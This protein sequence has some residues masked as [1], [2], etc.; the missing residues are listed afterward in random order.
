MITSVSTIKSQM[1]NHLSSSSNFLSIAD[2]HVF[3]HF[4]LDY[5]NTLYSF[6]FFHTLAMSLVFVWMFT[7]SLVSLS[8]P[9]MQRCGAT[10][11]GSVRSTCPTSCPSCRR[12]MRK[13]PPSRAHSEHYTL[14]TID[15]YYSQIR[16]RLPPHYQET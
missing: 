4:Q 7:M 3:I 16:N 15:A 9:R 10:L 1:F 5:C 13:R 14:H 8:V 2:L 12:S 11:C 6:I